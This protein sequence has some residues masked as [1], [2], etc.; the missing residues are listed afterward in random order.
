MRNVGKMLGV[1]KRKVSNSKKLVKNV[2]RNSKRLVKTVYKDSRR[3][4]M[5]RGGGETAGATGMPMRYYDPNYTSNKPVTTS[6]ATRYGNFQPN[7][8]LGPDCNLM[9]YSPY[10]NPPGRPF[11]MGGKRKTKVS[12]KKKKQRGGLCLQQGKN[13]LSSA[14]GYPYSPRWGKQYC[15]DGGKKKRSPKKKTTRKW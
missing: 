4:V 14:N 12:T 3:L 1:P 2:Y 9:P 11:K 10:S 5:G 7:G 13:L 15:A 6:V 8:C